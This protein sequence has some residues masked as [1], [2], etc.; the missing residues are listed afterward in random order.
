MGVYYAWANLSK[1]QYLECPAGNCG[2]KISGYLHEGNCCNLLLIFLLTEKWNRDQIGFL[3]DDSK[4]WTDSDEEF[5][6]WRD[7]S[8]EAFDEMKKYYRPSYVEDF[9]K[10]ISIC[11]GK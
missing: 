6:E 3:G 2:P 11:H 4:P 7:V 1:K 8:R 10:E 9:I 5:A